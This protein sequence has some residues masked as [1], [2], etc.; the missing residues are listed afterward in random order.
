MRGPSRV[1]ATDVQALLQGRPFLVGQDLGEDTINADQVL[2]S[3]IERMRTPVLRDMKRQPA[4]ERALGRKQVL[5][6]WCG[7]CEL[8]KASRRSD[9]AIKKT[10]RSL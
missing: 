2:L 10:A 8:A 9:P 4:L 3:G 5:C 7:V 6:S 1:L